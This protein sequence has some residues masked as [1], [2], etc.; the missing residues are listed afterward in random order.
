MTLADYSITAFA[1]LN[2]GRVMAYVPQIIRIYRDPYG[3][4]AVSLTTWWL[5]TAA[6]FATVSYAVTVSGDLV[7]AGVFGLNATGCLIIAGLTAAKRAWLQT[8]SASV[9]AN[10]RADGPAHVALTSRIAD[11][12]VFK[13]L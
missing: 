3:A 4:T 2:G 1:L 7:V 8:Q 6:N 13:G 11:A 10:A 9:I 5:F 12:I